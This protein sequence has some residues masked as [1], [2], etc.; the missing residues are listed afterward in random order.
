MTYFAWDYSISQKTLD[1]SCPKLLK[2]WQKQAQENPKEMTGYRQVP[3]FMGTFNP[4]DAREVYMYITE[5]ME[6]KKPEQELMN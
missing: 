3:S 2:E 4:E 5:K 6:L 1:C